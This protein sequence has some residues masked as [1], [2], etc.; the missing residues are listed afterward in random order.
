MRK[1]YLLYIQDNLM[2]I[3]TTQKQCQFYLKQ[4]K[5][6]K[7]ILSLSNCDCNGCTSYDFNVV[8][9]QLN[10]IPTIMDKDCN[11][12]EIIEYKSK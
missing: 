10:L 1:V 7:Q 2:G 11:I 8:V 5:S 12:L 9:K 3:Y 6:N 4:L